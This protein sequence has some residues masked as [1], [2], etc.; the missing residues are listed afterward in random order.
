MLD[1]RF[2]RGVWESV[3][4]DFV[5]LLRSGR[6]VV[7]LCGYLTW[8]TGL[9][10]IGGLKSLYCDWNKKLNYFS[11][12]IIYSWVVRFESKKFRPIT[13]RF[14]GFT[15]LL[16][17]FEISILLMVVVHIGRLHLQILLNYMKIVLFIHP[18]DYM[19][20]ELLIFLR[21]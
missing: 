10:S 7:C 8:K 13:M 9:D 3:A 2:E 18:K 15:S 20:F 1:W 21:Y 11:N 17:N 12:S 6:G 16:I 5:C 4:C 14:Y 19:I